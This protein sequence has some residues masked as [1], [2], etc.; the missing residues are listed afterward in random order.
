[1]PGSPHDDVIKDLDF[2]KLAGAYQITRD[3]DVSLGW[4]RFTWNLVPWLFLE[5]QFLGSQA[6][7][8]R[9]R[10]MRLLAGSSDYTGDPQNP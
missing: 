2:E 9:L 10:T 1:M 5:T 7:E 8:Q 6:C 4:G 3:L